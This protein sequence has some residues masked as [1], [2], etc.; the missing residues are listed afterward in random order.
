MP[1]PKRIILIRHGQSEGNVNKQIYYTTPDY[2]VQLTDSGI[3]QVKHSANSLKAIIGENPV[4]YYVSPFWRTRQTYMVLKKTIPEWRYYEDLRIREQEWLTSFQAV[5]TIDEKAR[6]SFGH[7]YY[8][9]GTGESNADV[10]DRISDFLNT[11]FRDFQKEDFPENTIIVTHG[12][13]MRVFLMRFFH[14]SVEEFELLANPRNAEYFIL[15]L[16][17]DGHYKLT[18]EP[19]KYEKRDHPFQFDWNNPK[20]Q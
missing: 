17:S 20:Y 16:G 2:A 18:T 9:F 5:D 15:E 11:L 4:A 13:A 1:K 19:R 6:D 12:M 3:N 10:Y 14:L 7:M 8:R